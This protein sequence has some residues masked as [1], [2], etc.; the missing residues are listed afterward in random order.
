M[1]E[2]IKDNDTLYGAVAWTKA[3]LSAYPRRSEK[4]WGTS[5]IPEKVDH[6][7][8]SGLLRTPGAGR[9]RHIIM[10]VGWEKLH[11]VTGLAVAINADDTRTQ[12]NLGDIEEQARALG[13]VH[14]FCEYR[15]LRAV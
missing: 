1:F 7:L 15:G 3:F 6:R 4:L 10:A 12:I 8:C 13:T 2:R 14:T 11:D 5:A 9:G